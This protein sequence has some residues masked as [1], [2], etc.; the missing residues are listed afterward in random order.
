MSI[1]VCVTFRLQGRQWSRS[2][3][4]PRGTTVLQL[5]EAMVRPRGTKEDARAFSL[6]RDGEMLF[7]AEPLHSDM[8]VEFQFVGRVDMAR[9]RR[10]LR[11]HKE[12]AAPVSAEAEAEDSVNWVEVVIKHAERNLESQIAVRVPEYATVLA[13]RQAVLKVLGERRLAEVRLV[14]RKGS[15]LHFIPDAEPIGTRRTFLSVGRR[16]DAPAPVPQLD[17]AR[18]AGD[19]EGKPILTKDQALR[20]QRELLRAFEDPAFQQKLRAL[21]GQPAKKRQALILSVQKEVLPKYGFE[22]SLKGVFFMLKAMEAF[23]NVREFM[24]AGMRINQ[25]LEIDQGGA[26]EFTGEA[27][28][29]GASDTYLQVQGLGQVQVS[30]QLLHNST[31]QLTVPRGTTV[32]SLKEMLCAMDATGSSKPENFRLCAELSP[33]SPLEETKEVSAALSK[34]RVLDPRPQMPEEPKIDA[35]AAA[36]AAPAEPSADAPG[37]AAA[38]PAPGAP[39]AAA[40][41]PDLE[42]L[43]PPPRR[44]EAPAEAAAAAGPGTPRTASRAFDFDDLEILDPSPLQPEV[45]AEATVD[46]PGTAAP[47]TA[48]LAAR[49]SDLDVPAARSAEADASRVAVRLRHATNGSSMTVQVPKDS[50]ILDLRKAAIQKLGQNKLF[51]LKVVKKQKNSFM[52]EADDAA[53]NGRTE[54]QTLGC[55][56]ADA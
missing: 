19:G 9:K 26:Q 38:E 40:R 30:V 8:R 41:A 25:L 55:D 36:G 27:A 47:G 11:L 51:N 16:L 43:E 44:P 4:I 12:A 24:E 34:L 17:R 28:S 39:R 46:A 32:L 3:T 22:G 7:D 29:K 53:I 33:E 1:E 10:E 21:A 14:A 50:T 52:S 6:L 45:P 2:F 56:L 15:G 23:Y 31:V 54:F 35:P 37:G 49:A 20:L 42:V 13:V 48:E 5:K 18:P